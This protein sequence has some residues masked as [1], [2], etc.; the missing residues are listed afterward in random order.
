M[1]SNRKRA[2]FKMSTKAP[3][4]KSLEVKPGNEA[5]IKMTHTVEPLNA[6]TFGTKQNCP[7]Y[8]GVHISGVFVENVFF[9]PI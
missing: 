5:T 9:K 8:R 3:S 6:D 4:P 1:A 2:R 7:D